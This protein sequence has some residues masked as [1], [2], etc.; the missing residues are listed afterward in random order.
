M[1]ATPKT[2]WFR[3]P[4]SG[5]ISEGSYGSG[6]EFITILSSNHLAFLQQIFSFGSGSVICRKSETFI[7][8]AV[9]FTAFDVQVYNAATIADW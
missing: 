9:E 8:L 5:P 3:R 7:T 4:V 2:A 1:L 6:D